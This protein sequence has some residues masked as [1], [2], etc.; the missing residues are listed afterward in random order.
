M[1][2][3]QRDDRPRARWRR[4]LAVP[5]VVALAATAAAFAPTAARAD[6]VPTP[7]AGSPT[8]YNALTPARLLDTRAGGATID[9]AFNGIGALGQGQTVDL[10][11]V[12]RGGV[13]ATGVGAVVLNVT[14]T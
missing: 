2:E 13:P 7:H 10:A 6:V 11:V 12:G 14:A 5:A 1:Q 8:S 9:G 4:R 3:P